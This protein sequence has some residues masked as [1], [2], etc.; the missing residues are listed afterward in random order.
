MSQLS[1]EFEQEKT[2]PLLK[3]LEPGKLFIIKGRG[4]QK[5]YLKVKSINFLNNSNLLADVFARGDSLVVNL[6]AGTVSVMNGNTEIEECV[7][8]LKV[9][10]AQ[11]QK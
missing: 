7:G 3:N 4:A 8:N 1:I 5:V 11:T 2:S 6:R 10:K 9:H